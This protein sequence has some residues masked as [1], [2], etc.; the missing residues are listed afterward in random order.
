MENVVLEI[1]DYEPE[2]QK[3]FEK[4]NRDWIEKYF[5]MEQ[6]DIDVLQNPQ[7]HILS[8]GGSIIMVKCDGEI[9]G[10]V[11]LKFVDNGIFEFT[12]MAVDAR[13]R[14]I[15]AGRLLAEAAIEKARSFGAKK[16]IL[17][18]NTQLEAAIRLYQKLGFVEIPLDGTYQ[19]SDTKMELNLT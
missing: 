4:L 19:R 17:Y 6:R 7:E 12:K 2:H 3:M 16:I 13:F 11:A 18:S 8:H 5:W 14:G 15:R 1:V 9:A 10:T